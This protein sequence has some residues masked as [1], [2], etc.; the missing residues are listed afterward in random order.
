MN[1]RV[2]LIKKINHQMNLVDKSKKERLMRSFFYTL[3]NGH[4]SI[5]K[6]M[7]IKILSPFFMLPPYG[8]MK[9]SNISS[10]KKKDKKGQ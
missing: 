6:N 3:I 2:M 4:K 8:I 9:F 5:A 1:L 7:D 10:I